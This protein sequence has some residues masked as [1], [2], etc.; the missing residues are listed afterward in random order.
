VLLS[1]RALTFAA[2]HSAAAAG[3]A[4]ANVSLPPRSAVEDAV[5]RVGP[6]GLHSSTS[7]LNMSC[8]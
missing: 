1:E 4:A 8:F 6:R 3:L 5:K 7:L 2:L